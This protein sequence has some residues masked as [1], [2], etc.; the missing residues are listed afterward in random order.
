MNVDLPFQNV[1]LAF[2][3]IFSGSLFASVIGALL[4]SERRKKKIA[5]LAIPYSSNLIVHR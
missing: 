1:P 4:L 2:M 3:G 5:N